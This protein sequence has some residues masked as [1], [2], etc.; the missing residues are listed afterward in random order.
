MDTNHEQLT[1][2][3][4]AERAQSQGQTVAEYCR[5][6]GMSPHVLYG[7]RRQMRK[8]GL[9]EGSPRRRRVGG[10]TGRFIAV[11]V[12]ESA[13]VP[14]VGAACRVRHPSGWIIECGSWP[15]PS[16]IKELVGERT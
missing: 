9:L 8:K 4:H 1:A 11:S 3:E 14:A 6:T 7:V 10:K 12:V 16:W 13:P 15:D 5:E 2:V